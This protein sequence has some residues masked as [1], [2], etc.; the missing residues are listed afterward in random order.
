M[1]GR[2]KSWIFSSDLVGKNHIRILIPIL[3]GWFAW[4]ARNES[5]HKG[6]K[7][8]AASMIFK[9]MNFI[10]LSQSAK[11]FSRDFW[12]GDIDIAASW[13]ITLPIPAV[14]RV[15]AVYWKKP[16]INWVKINTN[17]AFCQF[18][19]KASVGG[20][21]RDADGRILRGFKSYIGRASILYAELTGIW[22]G[23]KISKD[24]GLHNVMIKS[25]SKVALL[26][27]SKDLPNWHW[28]LFNLILK[29]LRLCNNRNIKLG[30]IFREGN[31]V[32]DWFAKSALSTRESTIFDPG[33]CPI[34]V[35]QI[36]YGDKM[37]MA[38][39]RIMKRN[40]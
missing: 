20:V 3:I 25:D 24:M 7:I 29:I 5:K 19:K 26:L 40:Q 6:K 36:A 17:G 18:S 12:R 39:V 16:P 11:S 33:D 38:Y 32:A 28:S 34:R 31:Q 23:L 4:L 9:I 22:Q 1:L 8:T 27:L 15:I 21:I 37:G 2:F 10:H 13:N 35:R 30:H 14:V